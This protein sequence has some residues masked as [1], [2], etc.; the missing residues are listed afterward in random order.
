MTG[1]EKA[2]AVVA[3]C[4]PTDTAH[5]LPFGAGRRWLREGSFLKAVVGGW[6]SNGVFRVQSGIPF[7]ITSS[8]CNV[9]S[10]VSATC[11][12]GLLPGESPFAQSLAHIDVTK[13][14]FN[15]SSFESAN[16]FNFYTGNGPRVQNFRQPAYSDFDMG[17]QKLVHISERVTFQ[18]RGDAFNVFNAHHF[19]TVGISLQGGGVGGSAFDTDV[20]SPSFGT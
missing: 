14:I 3:D 18:L 5:E 7:Q 2:R 12:P 19:N 4:S 17:L 1:S 11:V 16:S 10:Q 15:V 9:P 8:N 13:P 20:A 6:T